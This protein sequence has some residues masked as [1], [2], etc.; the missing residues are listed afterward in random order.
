[1]KKEAQPVTDAPLR[2]L[3]LLRRCWWT[4]DVQV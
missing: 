3:W 1:M 4:D 2:K